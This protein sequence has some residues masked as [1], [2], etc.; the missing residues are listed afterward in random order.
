VHGPLEGV[1]ALR[2]KSCK[3]K[4]LT[5]EEVDARY[6]KMD[7][8]KHGKALTNLAVP[9]RAGLGGG[10]GMISADAGAHRDALEHPSG[11]LGHTACFSSSVLCQASPPKCPMGVRDSFENCQRLL[12]FVLV[13]RDRDSQQ[14]PKT[15]KGVDDPALC[16]NFSP[17]VSDSFLA[18]FCRLRF[19]WVGSNGPRRHGV[20]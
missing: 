12:H 2:G 7:K 13:C 11:A 18:F 14:N 9:L 1:N 16:S 15:K 3:Y 5:Q 20:A 8:K 4:R 19:M 17:R 10:D 6:K